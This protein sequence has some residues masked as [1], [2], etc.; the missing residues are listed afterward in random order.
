[1]HTLCIKC[2]L[3]SWPMVFFWTYLLIFRS[4]GL[5]D[6]SLLPIKK[7]S[8]VFFL[9]LIWIP[10]FLMNYTYESTLAM[11]TVPI[12]IIGWPFF[13]WLFKP[14]ITILWGLLIVILGWIAQ[15]I[16]V[17]IHEFYYPPCETGLFILGR[18]KDI[19]FVGPLITQQYIRL[20]PVGEMIWWVLYFFK[21]ICEFSIFVHAFSSNTFLKP[22]PILKKVWLTLIIIFAAGTAFLFFN[23]VQQNRKIPGMG[24]LVLADFCI[25][26]FCYMRY[27]EIRRMLQFPVFSIITVMSFVHM[28]VWEFVHVAV[29]NNW[30]YIRENSLGSLYSFFTHHTY[31]VIQGVSRPHYLAV[32]EYGGYIALYVTI[33]VFL[34]W[35]SLLL[36]KDFFTKQSL[37]RTFLEDQNTTA[38]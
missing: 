25:L 16:A 7:I 26:L 12:I 4:T 17:G 28:T 2:L 11:E 32:E 9:S 20:M 22:V 3:A 19:P 34:V 14:K 35:G 33:I 31:P 36:K 38:R 27:A 13:I 5:L 15:V 8:A 24:F 37:M 10:F 6:K 30:R 21:I 29:L 18:F 1:M 23:F